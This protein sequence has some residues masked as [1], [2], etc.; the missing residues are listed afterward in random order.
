MREL[1]GRHREAA[2][3]WDE[4]GSPYDAAWA[5]AGGGEEELREGHERL[6]ELGAARAAALLARRL[7]ALGAS[8]V[9]RGP[10]PATRANPA[11]LTRREVEV[12]ELVAAGLRDADIAERLF[13]SRRTVGHHVSAILR[14]L[15]VA[16]RGQAAAA[17]RELGLV[18]GP[19]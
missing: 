10:R 12:L 15:D 19:T 13:L 17:A 5:L 7:R 3:R 18:A 6:R 9:A 8:D 16:T 14:K 1:A 11:G 4:L 2:A